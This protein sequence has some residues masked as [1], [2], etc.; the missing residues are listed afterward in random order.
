MSTEQ[1]AMERIQYL[2]MEL[3]RHNYLYYSEAQPEISD[4]EF[5]QLLEELQNLET[6]YPQYVQPDSPTQRV[7]GSVTRNFETVRH[8]Y[9]FLSLANSYSRDDLEAFDQRIRN[10]ISTPFTYVCELKFD[11]V[12]IGLQ[13]ENGILKRAVTRGDGAMGDDVT[14]NVKTIKRIPLSIARE[15]V[16]ER[17]EIRGELFMPLKSF[18]ALNKARSAE[19]EDLGYDEEQIR[20]RLFKNPRNAAAGTLKMQESAE[21]AKRKLDGF[22]YALMGEGLGIESHAASLEKARSLGF[23]VS[24]HHRI[25]ATLE[26]VFAFIDAWENERD[27]LPFDIDGVVVKVN[28]YAVQRAIG[29]TAKSP[30]WAIAFKY[31]AREAA[32]TLLDITYQVG[33][34]GAITPV[35]NLKPVFLSGT[36]VKRASLYNADYIAEM[37]IRVGDTVYIEKG[38][39]IIPKVVR[40]DPS[41]RN[42][43]SEPHA[44]ITHC[45]EC[46]S[47][48]QRREGEA[49]HYCPNEEGCPPQLLGRLIHFVGR[50]AMDINSL[51]EKTL[52]QMVAHGMLKNVAD[53]YTLDAA[54]IMQLEGFK[55]LSTQNILDGLQA[56]KAV[57]FER[58]L[59]A[60]GIRYVGETVA[61]KL[62]LRFKSMDALMAASEAE[63]LETDEIGEV[64]ARSLK[65]WFSR[66]EHVTMIAALKNQGLQMHLDEAAHRPKS[67]AL[68][69]KSFVVSGV[70]SVFSRDELK[71]TI[72]AHGGKVLSGVSASTT[73]LVAGDKMGPE[74]RKKAEKLQVPVISEQDFLAMIS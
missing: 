64:I 8:E 17:F 39:E 66:V 45:P 23:P 56:S 30:R 54:T 60:L 28:E 57:P 29:A 21:V 40:V 31:K 26:E 72:E 37:D 63:L 38:G 13:Y 35:A 15:T 9:P 24:E 11:G 59:F 25:C 36:T 7:G 73:Y 16:P 32:T 58:V 50:K 46:N 51:G 67:N 14:A 69:G 41:N 44:Y 27:A 49:I 3:N 5:D 70:F 53:L 74:K 19:L 20:E 47:P 61:R 18:E 34:T 1:L 52:E 2:V 6:L 62:A 71:K 42:L 10:A 4:W 65:D 43:F 48:L 22:M 33:R 12:A 68:E 55:A